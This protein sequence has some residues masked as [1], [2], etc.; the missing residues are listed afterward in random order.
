MQSNS[1][2]TLLAVWHTNKTQKEDSF[3]SA[4]SF[5]NIDLP[6]AISFSFSSKNLKPTRF[7]Y[8]NIKCRISIAWMS[9][10]GSLIAAPVSVSN[11]I[12]L[13]R[14]ISRVSVLSARPFVPSG[15]NVTERKIFKDTFVNSKPRKSKTSKRT[16]PE[17]K[18]SL[19]STNS[20]A[21]YIVGEWS[22]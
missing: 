18:N 1:N 17:E 12:V 15:H 7:E 20:F 6:A 5:K 9:Q 16:P 3:V 8:I 11:S 10:F 2:T 19:G 22:P 21:T 4:R 14:L 13:Y